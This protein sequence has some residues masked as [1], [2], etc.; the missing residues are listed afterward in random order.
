MKKLF[1]KDREKRKTIKLLEL[2]NF[3]LKQIS[4]V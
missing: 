4:G 2:E 1:A 3:K